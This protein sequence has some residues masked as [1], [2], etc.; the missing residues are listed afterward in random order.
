MSITN[1][2]KQSVS[3]AYLS[4]MAL[5]A[6]CFSSCS[7]SEKPVTQIAINRVINMPNQPEP[8]KMTDWYEKARH[9]D[10]Y[11]F[12]AELKGDFMPFL[13]IDSAKRNIPQNTFGL[14][15]VIGDVRQGANGSKE[16]HEAL[17]TMGSLF[18]AGLV[19]IDKTNQ[20]GMNYVKMTQNYF[21]SGNGWNI[22]MNNTYPGVALLGGGY[23]RDWWYDVFPNLLFYG[24]CELYP[25]VSQADSLQHI[26][27][28]QFFKADSVL[29]GNYN[30][31]FFDY[32]KMM[33]V[34]NNIPHQQDA[35]AG[36]AYILLCAYEKF[37]DERYLKGAISA[38]DAFV[39]QKESRFYEVL[40]PFGALVASRLNAEHGKDY[41]VKKILDWTFDGCKAADGR[42]GWGVIAE[43]W[44][45]YD[46]SGLQGSITDGGGYAF[47][48]NSFDMAWPLV[49][50]VRYDSRYAEA[51]G[52]WMLNVTNAA[53]L[54]YP[55]EIDDKH[56]WLPERKE[57]SKN[58]IAYEGLR[59]VDYTY[60]KEKLKGFTPVALGDGP[61]WVKGQ[62][63][64]S[65]FSLYSSAQVGIFG[66]M[67]R[68][69]NV[70]KILQLNCNA[71]DFYQKNSLPTFLYFNPYDTIKTVCFYN[72]SSS[73]VDLYNV[74]THE[75][76]MKAVSKDGCFAIPA[77]GAIVLVVIPAGNA[78]TKKNNQY[79]VGDKVIAY[80]YPLSKNEVSTH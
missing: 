75:Y 41:D 38:M 60:K 16:F 51:I 64:T 17:T 78:I 54:F 35:A 33:G 47:L 61:Q 25:G 18:S 71:T 59:K 37:G 23:G 7:S 43:R 53:R 22:M 67:V 80:D 8:Y 39:S 46:V 77:T 48:M 57:I 31:S 65:M 27:A 32:G 36:H 66:A 9:Y 40:M 6:F 45:D 42:T 28:E 3:I 11:V 2:I 52:K 34:S 73:E 70:D 44:G 26:I 19:G 49:P 56:Q 20:N 15:T 10:Q 72:S 58:V 76:L 29:K 69:T 21:N 30:Y 12:N 5:C 14:Y 55:Y 50:M 63:E 24:L 79:R 74:L 62:P 4:V 1:I 68:K 13:W